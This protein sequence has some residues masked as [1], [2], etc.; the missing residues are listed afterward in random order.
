MSRLKRKTPNKFSSR[1]LKGKRTLPR[2]T[3]LKVAEAALSV[4]FPKIAYTVSVLGTGGASSGEARE[5]VVLQKYFDPIAEV[6]S[7]ALPVVTQSSSTAN[8]NSD[9]DALLPAVDIDAT[10]A[11]LRTALKSDASFA[12]KTPGTIENIGA[13]LLAIETVVV[14]IS[15]SVDAK[16]RIRIED[17]R[18]SGAHAAEESH[19]RDAS[20]FIKCLPL[21]AAKL[22]LH[23]GNDI[24]SLGDGSQE[25]LDKLQYYTA[26]KDSE[27]EEFLTISEL[28]NAIARALASE[29][30]YQRVILLP[31]DC[32][33]LNFSTFIPT[34]AHLSTL[35]AESEGAATQDSPPVIVRYGEGAEFSFQREQR[36]LGVAQTTFSANHR[37][38]MQVVTPATT[39]DI[40][41][42][43]LL[44]GDESF[45]QV[46]AM[47]NNSNEEAWK[48]QMDDLIQ[49]VL[50]Q[51]SQGLDWQ[52]FATCAHFS[53]N[54][55]EPYHF[56]GRIADVVFGLLE[57]LTADDDDA[58]V[59]DIDPLEWLAEMFD[60]LVSIDARD[61]L[62]AVGASMAEKLLARASAEKDLELTTVFRFL[63][64]LS[65]IETTPSALRTAIGARIQQ[66]LSRIR[67]T[68]VQLL[69]DLA[70][71]L[72]EFQTIQPNIAEID[73]AVVVEFVLAT[74]RQ[75]KRLTETAL[76]QFV[77]EDT[78]L[79]RYVFAQRRL[80]ETV[81]LLEELA[82]GGKSAGGSAFT[83]RRYAEVVTDMSCVLS[84]FHLL[85]ESLQ[86]TPTELD[87][88]GV[89]PR[90]TRANALLSEIAESIRATR[91]VFTWM[92]RDK[93]ASAPE[94]FFDA[95]SAGRHRPVFV[96]EAEASAA[97]LLQSLSLIE[98]AANASSTN[99]PFVNIPSSCISQLFGSWV[100][101]GLGTTEQL[102]VLQALW[103]LFATHTEERNQDTA[104]AVFV[105]PEIENQWLL[106]KSES[107]EKASY[108][109]LVRASLPHAILLQ[110]GTEGEDEKSSINVL[111]VQTARLLV[112]SGA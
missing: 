25:M 110:Q 66:Q 73:S 100:S 74:P 45:E 20:N 34:A 69:S 99:N 57:N 44:W 95:A 84:V 64:L 23:A 72:S 91:A 9:L 83:Q 40:V 53:P 65:S 27:D 37:P 10:C 16:G 49:T 39:F 92:W 60:Y 77:S 68:N 12:K 51:A 96:V 38:R 104:P 103:Q 55:Q 24:S 87:E 14:P 58:S 8:P 107:E 105:L 31:S 3:S 33:H 94:V 112:R 2:K 71:F 61:W 80:A 90:E 88:A 54:N 18:P 21:E 43:Q 81:P 29:K 102:T 48:S 30:E 46:A 63:A 47:A 67:V 62:V 11:L 7:D 101:A 28:G 97:H 41:K 89:S 36:T 6:F 35:A 52:L 13:Q 1:T 106:N 56:A 79:M 70:R 22:L 98:T 50:H 109:D 26:P 82:A 42:R 4:P 108:L 17:D 75:K 32:E 15:A 59:P 76:K 85:T 93:F 19:G 111:D 5:S 86:A 78:L